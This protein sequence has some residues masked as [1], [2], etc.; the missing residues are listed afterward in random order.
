MLPPLP[1][2]T[3]PLATPLPSIPSIT[4]NFPNSPSGSTALPSPSVSYLP[5]PVDSS[6]SSPLALQFSPTP[7]PVALQDQSHRFSQSLAPSEVDIKAQKWA[8]MVAKYGDAHLRKHLWDFVDNEYL[9]HYNF[10]PLTRIA[11]IWAEWTDGIEGYLSVRQLDEGWGARWRRNVGAKKTEYGRRKKIVDL[12]VWLVA[13]KPRWDT[14][15]ALRFLA[16][17]FQP[18]FKTARSFSDYLTPDNGPGYTEV[19]NA[20]ATYP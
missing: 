14:D 2:Q 13:N 3:A 7:P 8:L 19:R 18:R 12:V 4:I 16:D 5:P 17:K 1:L 6:W 9:P 20:A 10:R 11:D 15:L